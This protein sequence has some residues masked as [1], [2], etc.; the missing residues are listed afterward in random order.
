MKTTILSPIA[1][2]QQRKIAI[3]F[4]KWLVLNNMWQCDLTFEELYDIWFEKYNS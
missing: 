1:E 3:E 2:K 4:S